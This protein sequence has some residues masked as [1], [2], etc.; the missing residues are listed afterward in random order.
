MFAREL[1]NKLKKYHPLEELAVV[2]VDRQRFKLAM[3]KEYAALGY[4]H[5]T[6]PEEVVDELFLK[7]QQ[8]IQ[9]DAHQSM[10]IMIAD[11][12]QLSMRRNRGDY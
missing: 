6:I 10:T 3:A 2:L 12:I 8:N 7:F 11:H 9:I 4:H 5:D 1:K